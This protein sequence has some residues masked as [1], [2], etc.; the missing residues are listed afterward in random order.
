MSAKKEKINRE[1]W[2]KDPID[3]AWKELKTTKTWTKKPGR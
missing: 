1:I 2:I 3:G